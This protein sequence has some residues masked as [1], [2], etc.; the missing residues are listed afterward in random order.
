MV[1]FLLAIVFANAHV[2]I[3]CL[4]FLE[5]YYVLYFFFTSLRVSFSQSTIIIWLLFWRS[6]L[7]K[8]QWDISIVF[9]SLL[10]DL[11]LWN[12]SCSILIPRRK[13]F[14]YYMCPHLWV[15]IFIP[16]LCHSHYWVF[17]FDFSDRPWLI[18][19]VFLF[20]MIPEGGNSLFGYW[21]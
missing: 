2:T 6:R 5:F 3:F 20:R 4:I 1:D 18:L 13:S 11:S 15:W 21:W 7:L 12:N 16:S 14:F 10:H 17:Y 19:W 9:I 8:I